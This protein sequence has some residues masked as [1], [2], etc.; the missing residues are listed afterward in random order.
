MPYK[1][2][3]KAKDRMRRNYL[4][5]REKQIQ[6]QKDRRKANPFEVD[7][8]NIISKFK[9]RSG[10]PMTYEEYLILYKR[11]NGKCQICEKI[12][13]TKRR[14]ALDHCHR[15]N[16]VRGFL[17]DRCNRGIGFLL[18]DISILEKAI[19][20]LKKYEKKI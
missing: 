9:K 17:C 3:Q 11:D 1:D 19:I 8:K 10:L 4:K 18:D 16:I 13:D 12:N 7:T 14:I 2:P 15:K 6:R 5:N 20:Y